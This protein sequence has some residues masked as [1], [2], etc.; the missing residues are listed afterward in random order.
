MQSDP[1]PTWVALSRDHHNH[2]ELQKFVNLKPVIASGPSGGPT[3]RELQNSAMTEV[4]R[5]VRMS[6]E[7]A[8]RIWNFVSNELILVTRIQKD[9][10][11]KSCYCRNTLWTAC[12]FSMTVEMYSTALTIYKLVPKLWDTLNQGVVFYFEKQNTFSYLT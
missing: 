7:G 4:E 11:V 10:T 5:V 12:R 6:A 2:S 1:R 8:K 9:L 3:S